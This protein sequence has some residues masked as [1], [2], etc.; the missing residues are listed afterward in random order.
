MIATLALMLLFA[1]PPS[2]VTTLPRQR[3][4]NPVESRPVLQERPTDPLFDRPMVATDDQAF[5]LGAIE[6]LVD[7]VLPELIAVVRQQIGDRPLQLRVDRSFELVERLGRG[8]VDA[9]IVV[10]PA[11]MLAQRPDGGPG[12]LYTALTRSTRALALVH[13]DELPTPLRDA[14][15]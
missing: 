8:E 14:L 15:N 3:D 6:N 10:E 9:A 1:D 11:A 12:G 4:G 13:A 2:E 7:P 5:V